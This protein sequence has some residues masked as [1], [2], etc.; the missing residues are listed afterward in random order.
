MQGEWMQICHSAFSGDVSLAF[1][2]DHGC[3][4]GCVRSIGLIDSSRRST[5]LHRIT[6]GTNNTYCHQQEPPLL[7]AG[8]KYLFFKH[9]TCNDDGTALDNYG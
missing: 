2:M 9:P 3:C 8:L 1:N 5:R 4:K 6:D 7:V